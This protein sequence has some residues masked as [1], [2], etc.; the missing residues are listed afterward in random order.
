MPYSITDWCLQATRMEQRLPLDIKPL[1][2]GTQDVISWFKRYEIAC[3]VRQWGK[4]EKTE[5]IRLTLL[6]CYVDDVALLAL[7]E[8][9]QD[10]K[11]DYEM[12]KAKLIDRYSRSPRES[13]VDFVTAK[14]NGN[15]PVDSF[16]DQLR[17]VLLRACPTLDAESVETLVL[18]QF[19]EGIPGDKA[20]QI[21]LTVGKEGTRMRLAAVLEKARAIFTRTSK[22]VTSSSYV[23][24][25]AAM[26]SDKDGKGTLGTSADMS[27]VRCFNCNEYGHF[28]GKCPKPS[29]KVSKNSQREGAR[30][31]SRQ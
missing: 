6:P 10:E 25:S 2:E 29:K 17:R 13:F 22:T 26:R 5:D 14:Y 20:N 21:T 23:P 28:A 3:H 30:V 31:P 9:G 18:L 16:A 8:L 11:I 1:S 19:L 24:I 15:S 4:A 12:A 7:E 27:K